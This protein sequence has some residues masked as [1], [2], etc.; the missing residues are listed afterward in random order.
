MMKFKFIFWVLGTILLF[1]GCRSEYTRAVQSGL[2]SGIIE[3]SL[4]FGM[5]MGMT[6]KDF[7]DTCWILN[8]QKLISEG[9]GNLSAKYVEPDSILPDKTLRKSMLFYGIFDAKDTMRGMT[10]TYSYTAWAPWIRKCQSDSLMSDLMRFYRKN[11]PGN[12]F[13][14]IDIEKGIKAYAKV[15]GNRQIVVYPMDAKDVGV[16]FEDLRYK[17]NKK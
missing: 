14:T 15:D 8:K 3:D 13:I 16:K 6:K 1:A 12:D 7:Y 17:L 4:I 5:K 10:F 2:G 11:Y 9:P